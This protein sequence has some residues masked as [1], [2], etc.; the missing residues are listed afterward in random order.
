MEMIGDPMNWPTGGGAALGKVGVKLGLKELIPHLAAFGLSKRKFIPKITEGAGGRNML[1]LFD[2]AK[3]LVGR[4]GY[5]QTPKGVGFHSI[6]VT[7]QYR[8][9]GSGAAYQM[10][11]ELDD[12][13]GREAM[14]QMKMQTPVM[15]HAKGF[16]EHLSDKISQDA[17]NLADRMKQAAS[18]ADYY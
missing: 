16:F 1:E 15:P 3:G 17:P 5:Q 6:M 10:F 13:V 18:M 7:P 12:L 2:Q 9:K 14:D 11:D 4:L 8:G